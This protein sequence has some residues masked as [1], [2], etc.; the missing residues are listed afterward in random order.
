MLSNINE[1]YMMQF[2][3]KIC[4]QIGNEHIYMTH[5][6]IVMRRLKAVGAGVSHRIIRIACGN[7]ECPLPQ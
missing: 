3:S 7:A 6:N 2:F 4:V 1:V 5:V